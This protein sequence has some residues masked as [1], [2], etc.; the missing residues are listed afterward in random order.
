ML[1]KKNCL[2]SLSTKL[3]RGGTTE[4]FGIMMEASG[5]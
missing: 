4:G 1:V 5:L 2:V 3:R